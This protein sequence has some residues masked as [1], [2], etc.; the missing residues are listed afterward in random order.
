MLGHHFAGGRVFT[1]SF[2]MVVMGSHPGL[3]VRLRGCLTWLTVFVLKMRLSRM[4]SLFSRR[5]WQ[6]FRTYPS[7]SLTPPRTHRGGSP[8]TRRILSSER[9]LFACTIAFHVFSWCVGCL[10][11]R[12]LRRILITQTFCRNACD[13]SCHK[14]DIACT[15][16]LNKPSYRAQR[17]G[18]SDV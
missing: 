5:P 16:S 15:R 14:V 4:H 18:N 10:A 12:A 6:L 2:R 1:D 9:P 8:T 3:R 13:H 7:V 11:L 17:Q